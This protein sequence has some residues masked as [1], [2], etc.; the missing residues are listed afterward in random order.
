[1]ARYAFAFDASLTTPLTTC[2]TA[3]F[4]IVPVPILLFVAIITL[5]VGTDHPNGKWSDRHKNAALVPAAV[6]D[7]SPRGSDDIEA[8]RETMVPAQDGSK[9]KIENEKDAVNVDVTAVMPSREPILYGVLEAS[10]DHVG[11]GRL[12]SARTACR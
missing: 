12:R 2:L 9:E 5:L 8:I 4:A 3:A 10:T 1:M 7:G 11:Q 6:T